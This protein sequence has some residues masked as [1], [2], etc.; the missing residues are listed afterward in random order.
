[1]GCVESTRV[2]HN[3]PMVCARIMN[4]SVPTDSSAVLTRN[5]ALFA[6]ICPAVH[7][8]L[9]AYLAAVP[10]ALPPPHWDRA[11][12]EHELARDI[13]IAPLLG[14]HGVCVF[15]GV[16][17]GCLLAFLLETSGDLDGLC[18]P[19]VIVVE[20]D[21]TRLCNVLQMHDL[22]PFGGVLRTRQFTWFVGRTWKEQYL[23][24]A[25]AGELV[26]PEDLL[27]FDAHVAR[28]VRS[29]ARRLQTRLA[30]IVNDVNVAY[31]ASATGWA[32]AERPRAVLLATRFS[33]VLPHCA[34]DVARVLER[35]GWET[36]CLIENHES[37]VMTPVRIAQ[38]IQSFRPHLMM[39]FNRFRVD[40]VGVL[41][42]ELVYLT[43]LQD[44]VPSIES[45]N[46]REHIGQRDFVMTAYESTSRVL[47]VPASSTFR[48]QCFAR[49]P[50]F[51]EAPHET[52][53]EH[54]IVYLSNAGYTDAWIEDRTQIWARHQRLSWPTVRELLH[55]M[56][57]RYE[58]DDAFGSSGELGTWLCARLGLDADDATGIHRWSSCLGYAYTAFHRYQSLRWAIAGARERGLRVAIYGDGWSKRPEFRA[59]FRGKT[60]KG[61]E[62]ERIQRVSRFTLVAEPNPALAHWR[63]LECARAGGFPIFRA[64]PHNHVFGE[65]HTM[66][67]S[68]GT[69]TNEDE[70]RERAG[71]HRRTDVDDLLRRCRATGLIGAPLETLAM[72]AQTYGTT[73]VPPD[74]EKIA[75]ANPVELAQVID[76]FA[77]NPSARTHV[78]R[79]VQQFVT[80]HY[81]LEDGISA[82]LRF[83]DNELRSRGLLGTVAV[84]A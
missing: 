39:G 28:G 15:A 38:T 30:N 7:A 76:R 66:V 74:I 12:I 26:V 65:L 29:V 73:H 45:G 53:F 20:P 5:L 1:M 70:L 55:D 19:P 79:R 56:R 61:Y 72:L 84:A 27:V 83:I 36:C 43:W 32:G 62:G 47:G 78:R 41:P 24:G 11:K 2:G 21:L 68:L 8:E 57:A 9:I 22:T 58:A 52:M 50:E 33:P 60:E 14:R 25:L 37:D 64:H 46:M 10:T 34:R 82:V 54:D 63:G 42:E 77:A 49:M 17:Y 23:A 71:E 18:K 16:G 31:A 48:C 67:T 6:G 13:E 81:A 3:W 80:R 69:P 4:H 75:F 51:D 35:A 44:I 59:Y 40:D